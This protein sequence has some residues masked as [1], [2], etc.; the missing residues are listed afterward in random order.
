[1]GLADTVYH[2]FAI[3]MRP[4]IEVH[5]GIVKLT[6]R[7][8]FLRANAYYLLAASAGSLVMDVLGS[9][10]LRGPES[11]LIAAAP[12]TGA[13]FLEAHGLALILGIWF[14]CAPSSRSWHL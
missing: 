6:T 7:T 10:F 2:C 8:T 4:M 5:G 12:F 13:G 3:S 1:M 14:W 11:R 9:F